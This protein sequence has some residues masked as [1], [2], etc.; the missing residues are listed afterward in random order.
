[1]N[2]LFE[3]RLQASKLKLKYI[4]YNFNQESKRKSIPAPIKKMMWEKYVSKELRMGKCFCC[5]DK[6]ILETDCHAG[7][8]ISD[9]DGGRVELDN[10]RPICAKCN[11][12]MGS[13]NM[14]QFIVKYN[15]W[16]M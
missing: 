14:Y 8:V 6:D 10:L 2:K 11:L 12:S 4:L 9:K 7:H 16:N 13:E 15:M 1:M 5:Q 3:F